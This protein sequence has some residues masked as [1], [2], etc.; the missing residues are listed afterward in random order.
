MR[1][2]RDL[3]ILFEDG[4][5]LAV[6]KPAGLL[7][8]P[9]PARRK[10]PDLTGMLRE[11]FG[12]GLLGV[13]RIDAEMGGVMVFAKN[14]KARDFLT[15]QF[16]SKTVRNLWAAICFRGETG[17]KLPAVLEAGA[18]FVIDKNLIGDASR[19]GCVVV[20]KRKGSESL[21]RVK[22]REVFAKYVFVEAEPVT[23]RTHQARAHLE[24]V[25]LPVLNDTLYGK[26]PPLFLSDLKRGYKG[27]GEER[28][29][30]GALAL[31]AG[32]LTVAHPASKERLTIRADLPKDFEIALKYLRKFP[33]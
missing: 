6:S 16:Q 7:V 3:E 25:G 5:L 23:Q 33:R 10:E 19:P 4:D 20:M 2:M 30:M 15:G 8:V 31:H 1:A 14:E 13:H 18:E 11:K 26:V 29:L 9:H 24:S 28:P 27:R 32:E 21:T 12:G 17:D 22:V